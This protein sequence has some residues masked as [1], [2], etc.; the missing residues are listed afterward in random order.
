[1][2]KLEKITREFLDEIGFPNGMFGYDDAM[3]AIMAICNNSEIGKKI[4]GEDGLYNYVVKHGGSS[5]IIRVERNI[6][7]AIE[8]A[9]SNADFDIMM[10]YM[11]GI[12]DI[13][14]GKVI[15]RNFLNRAANIVLVRME[16]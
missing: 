12:Y 8:Y 5:S 14:S 16:Q 7:T 4:C 10:K 9:F 2:E 3:I 6:R 15:N 11:N 1:M 13:E